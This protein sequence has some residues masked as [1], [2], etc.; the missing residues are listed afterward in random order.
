[1]RRCTSF[2]NSK[3]LFDLQT[4]F[5]NVFKHYKNNLKRQIPSR[6]FDMNFETIKYGL[7]GPTQS[8]KNLPEK[9]MSDEVEMKCI[10]IINTCDYILDIIPQLQSSIEDKID[11]EYKDKID[12]ETH[13]DDCFKE[14][15][16]ASI[17]CLV[18]SLCARNDKI[19]QNTLCK[20]E[21][22]KF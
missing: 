5:K 16:R 19:Y 22:G 6:S 21:W 20:M 13:A 7:P 1:M 15:I 17:N 11:N 18:V 9:A 4:T 3:A 12:L 14:L 8:I 2:S 10:Y